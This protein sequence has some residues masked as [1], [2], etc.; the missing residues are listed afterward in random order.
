MRKK[1][2]R[3]IDDPMQARFVRSVE[4]FAGYVLAY[5]CYPKREF[6]VGRRENL[7]RIAASLK[8]NLLRDWADVGVQVLDGEYQYD[9]YTLVG[10]RRQIVLRMDRSH[11][12]SR[13]GQRDR[14]GWWKKLLRR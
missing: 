11:K 8:G 4:P 6:R 13:N 5:R 9:V 12:E 14:W 2:S 3:Y 10:R 1:L 7:E